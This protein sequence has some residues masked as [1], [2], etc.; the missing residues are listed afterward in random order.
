MTPM[1]HHVRRQIAAA[2]DP[3]AAA[4]VPLPDEPPSLS[5]PIVDFV[6]YGE[7]CL[8]VGRLRMGDGRLTDLLNERDEYEI[9]DIAAERLS[10]GLSA[11]APALTVA[12]RELLLVQAAGPR[13][14]ATRRHRTTAYPIA[15]RVGPYRVRGQLHALPGVDPTAIIRRRA[16]MVPLT[17]AW[18]DLPVGAERDL[19]RVGTVVLNRDRLDWVVATWDDSYGRTD[20]ELPDGSSSSW[21]DWPDEGLDGPSFQIAPL[22]GE[23]VS[24][25]DNAGAVMRAG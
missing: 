14:D 15:A 3:R 11:D 18:I 9:V 8:L 2:L 10:D 19:H 6:A 5:G 4:Q 16:P 17:D 7:D 20:N 24:G 25:P 22:T 1:L 13:G 12:R 23:P 21:W